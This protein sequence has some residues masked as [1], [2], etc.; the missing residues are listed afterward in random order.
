MPQHMGLD[1]VDFIKAKLLTGLIF[2]NIAIGADDPERASRNTS[3]ARLAL[4]TVL[5]TIGEVQLSATDSAEIEAGLRELRTKLTHL[6]ES[7]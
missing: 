4:G 2:A 3:N 6:G 5:Q 1:G 7:F